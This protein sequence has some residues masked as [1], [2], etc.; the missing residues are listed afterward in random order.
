[1]M[2]D[3]LAPFRIDQPLTADELW[4][5][6]TLRSHSD[7]KE[8]LQM[9]EDLGIDVE[10]VGWTRPYLDGRQ[11]HATA[12]EQV[13]RQKLLPIAI[14]MDEKRIRSAAL[15]FT[16]LAL[17]L[18]VSVLG[19]DHPDTLTSEGYLAE[20]LRSYDRSAEALPHFERVLEGATRVLGTDH[21]DTI[22]RC[23]NLAACLWSLGR[24]GEALPLLKRTQEASERVLGL[25]HP[26]TLSNRNIL[27]ACLQSLGLAGE[28]FP[29]LQSTQEMSE[30]VLGPDHSDTIS[31]ATI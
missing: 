28:A 7:G 1:M 31:A 25:E 4:L 26:A 19:P 9:L 16:G 6:H 17:R 12:I 2:V 15:G 20:F 22:I 18:G 8:L 24:A 11:L 10:Q 5:L 21:P 30:R 14:R 3:P 13:I 23:S 29:L 27:A